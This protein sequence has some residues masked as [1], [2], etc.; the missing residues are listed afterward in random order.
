MRKENDQ[1]MKTHDNVITVLKNDLETQSQ[2]FQYLEVCNT[3]L[4]IDS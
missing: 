1:L 3:T 4:P 2:K